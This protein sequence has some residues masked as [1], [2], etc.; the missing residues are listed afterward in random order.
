MSTGKQAVGEAGRALEGRWRLLFCE[1]WVFGINL[2]ATHGPQI[3]SALRVAAKRVTAL[4][5]DVRWSICDCCR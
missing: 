1:R 4:A 2:D 3:G 5:S